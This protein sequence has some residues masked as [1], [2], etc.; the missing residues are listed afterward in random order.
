MPP[1]QP[2][3]KSF[4]RKLGVFGVVAVIVA[5]VVVVTGIMS[6][7]RSNAQLREWTE[8][9]AILSVATAPPDAKT[10]RPVLNLPGRLEAY[11]RAPIFARVSGYVK[12]WKV[13]IGA[14]VK[15]GQLLAEI[16]APDLDQQ[17]L[18]AR[19]DLLNA[20]AAAKLSEATLT[21][22]QALVKSNIV[23]QQDLDER[24]A[25]LSIKQGAVKANQANVERLEALAA[26]KRVT[27]PFDGF[28]TARDTDVGA[29][30]NGGGSTGT[31][32]FV[33]SDTR[34]L[35]V[36]VNVPQTFVPF[37]RIG[38]K[39]FISVPE[40][41]DRA[42]P[43]ALEFS[44]QSI[45]GATGTT[46]MQL[47]VDNSAGAMLPGGYANVR[48]DLSRDSQ[49]LHIPASALIFGQDGLKVATVGPDDRVVF[50]KIVIG[51]DLGQEI[52]IAS[53]LTADDQIITSP[54]DGLSDGLQVRVVN[55][56]REKKPPAKQAVQENDPKVVR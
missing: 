45:D 21:R 5:I 52:E 23:T 22:R 41:P 44:A 32:M 56:A 54:P 48:V 29:L 36:Y 39:T 8:T 4:V 46:R 37:V 7:E 50:K 1:D 28:V 35:R 10:L 12:E 16:E 6:R 42:F 24:S 40:Y 18:Q 2:V 30:I 53:G 47:I 14:P 17:L 26:Y 33:I 9:Q 38:V 55:A 43:A 27:A 31:P 49:P 19:A 20:Q 15:A 3:P 13:D 25:D 34:K 11:A 51:R